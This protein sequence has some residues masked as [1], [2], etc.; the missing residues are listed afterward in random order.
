MYLKHYVNNLGL[1]LGCPHLIICI[2]RSLYDEI[3]FIEDNIFL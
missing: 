3:L 1:Y 2:L